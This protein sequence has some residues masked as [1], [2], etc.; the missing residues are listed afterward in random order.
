MIC[1]KKRR[2]RVGCG[3]EE[4]TVQAPFHAGDCREIGERKVNVAGGF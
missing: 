2:E 1:L 3:P 4:Q